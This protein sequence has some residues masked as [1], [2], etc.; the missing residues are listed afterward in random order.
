MSMSLDGLVSGLSTSDL[1]AKL[2]QLERAPQQ[3]LV[4]KRTAA[5]N[6]IQALQGLNTKLATLRDAGTSLATPDRWNTMS[7]TSTSDA[8]AT[9]SASTSALA[10]SLSFN[11]SSLAV[12]GGKASSGTVSTTSAVVSSGIVLLA[13]G[14]STIGVSSVKAGAGLVAGEHEIEVTQQSAAA[15]KTGTGPI[16]GNVNIVAGVNDALNLTVNG[17]ATPITLDVGSWSTA[18][19]AA[20]ITSKSGGTVVASDQSGMLVLRTAAHGSSA[21]IEVAAGT[22]EGDLNLTVG[23]GTA[24]IDGVVEV[25]GVSN[26]L[27]FFTPGSGSANVNSDVGILR[28]DFAPG[29]LVLGTVTTHAISTGTGTLAETAAAI[30]AAKKGISA[31]VVQVAPSTFRLQLAATASGVANDIAVADDAFTAIG[32][33]ASTSVA[34]N[35][36]ITVGS[37]AGQYSVTSATNTITSLLPGVTLT[38]K[39]TGAAT[40]NVARDTKTVADSVAAMVTFANS[41]LTEIKNLTA[42]NTTTGTGSVLTGSFALRTLQSRIITA[43]VDAV[44]ISTLGSAGA[45]GVSTTKT[46]SLTFDRAKFESAY[47]A[48]ADE[49]AAL[50]KAGGTATSPKVAFQSATNATLVGDYAV[51]I[52]VAAERAERIGNVT[53]GSVIAANETIELRVG[54]ATGTTVSYAATAGESLA[55]IADELNALLAA[56][57]LDLAVTV[58]G[59]ALAVRTGGYGAGSK[60]EVQTS[61]IGANQTGLATAPAVWEE[62]VGVDVD[63][64]ID[65]EVATGSGQLLIAPADD[66]E[67]AGLVLKITATAADVLLSTDFGSFEYQPGVAKRLAMV[68]NGAVDTVNGTLTAL[69]EGRETE[70]ERITDRIERWDVQLERREATLRRQFTAMEMALQRMQGQSQWLAG[71]IASMQANSAASR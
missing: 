18:Q 37:G 58:E 26:T 42:V 60:F 5:N 3:R 70:I 55:S 71:Q 25:N 31:A 52:N 53:A 54:G 64:T 14:T 20:Q 63:G 65:G 10:G 51:V 66:D 8:V 59:G 36:T 44:E 9:A 11:V 43:V 61:V 4:T 23:A 50:F 30:N 32:N 40:V 29:G 6:E 33:L 1:I 22:A 13:T 62:Y 68:S 35:A 17:V 67:L 38:V 12:A 28:L 34:S 45:A 7:A 19:L 47:A 57:S 46:G 48:N 39:S 69:I 41:A 15:A 56:Q 24:G 49:V 2:M 16:V 21:T 27:S